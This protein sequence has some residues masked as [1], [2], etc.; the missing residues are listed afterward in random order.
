MRRSWSSLP[1]PTGST[2]S[3]RCTPN[4]SPA[5]AAQPRTASPCG[6]SP[7]RRASAIPPT[8][9]RITSARRGVFSEGTRTAS[10]Y[11][12]LK[13]AMDYWCA[14]WFWP[15]DRA[16]GLP[17]RDEFLNEI[18]LVL[19]GSVFQPGLGPN[20]TADLFGDE[21]A[22]HAGRHR[23]THRQRDRHARPGQAVRAVPAPEAG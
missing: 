6:G 15:I 3:G 22:E 21:Y 16:D 9:G 8:P 12:H 1:C 20:Q 11:R 2:N 4:S 19:T 13:L 17:K 18:A 7:P 23:E 14:L 5:T 10:H